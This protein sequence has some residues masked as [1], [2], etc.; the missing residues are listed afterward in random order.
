MYYRNVHLYFLSSMIYDT[1]ELYNENKCK[2]THEHNI[3]RVSKGALDLLNTV[4]FI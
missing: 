4:K 1:T 2:E 3:Q